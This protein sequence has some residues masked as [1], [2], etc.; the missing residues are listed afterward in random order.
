MSYPPLPNNLILLCEV[1]STAH[2]TGIAGGEDTDETAVVIEEPGQIFSL[3]SELK[4]YMQRTQ[5]EGTRSKAGD[6]D[7]QIYSLRSFLKLAASGNPS[8][9]LAFWAPI[10]Q[11]TP[12]GRDLRDLSPYII[13]R[14]MIPR[15]RGY[16]NGQVMRMEG[17]KGNGH[18]KRGGGKREE[19]IAEFG[20]DRKFGMHAA[21]LGFQ[22][23]ELLDT[24]Q[25][26]LPIP[27]ETGEFLRAVR[28][29]GVPKDEW[30]IRVQELD[31]AMASRLDDDKIPMHPDRA[32]IERFSINAHMSH[33]SC[34]GITL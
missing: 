13:S 16:M 5:P 17:L 20:W 22:C 30:R 4:N 23:L 14:E 19:L 21:R 34:G 12:W 26:Q 24:G 8:I 3:G 11:A 1:G 6:T 31:D 28:N 10:I 33:W 27:G 29:G 25:L 2:G 18:G 7:R 15:Y 9:Q 32:L